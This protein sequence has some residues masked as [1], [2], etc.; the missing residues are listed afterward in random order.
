MTRA[1]CPHIHRVDAHFAG[2]ISAQEEAEMRRHLLEGCA[3]C[4]FRYTR[5]AMVAK[6]QP[7][8]A[9]ARERIAAGLGF[10]PRAFPW[11]RSLLFGLAAIA[12]MIAIVVLVRDRQDRFASRG[13]ANAGVELRVFQVRAGKS[14]PVAN[15]I[16]PTDELAFAYRDGTGK[17]HLFIFGVDEHRHVYWFSP[18]WRSA[19]E[20]PAAP[21]IAGDGAFHE[22]E[23]AVAHPYDGA[24]L[25]VYGLF[26]DR[27]WN[28]AEL[29]AAISRGA[30][31][32][33]FPDGVLTVHHLAIAR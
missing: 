19:A 16:A 32:L 18:A 27:P 28:V 25:D 9:T 6:V 24:R 5:L 26:T 1:D 17:H 4:Q 2:R 23:D 30:P 21:A 20:R 11:G 12:A 31:A 22:I 7:G 8:A 33:S 10:G 14:L 15:Q 13:S 3:A 29:D